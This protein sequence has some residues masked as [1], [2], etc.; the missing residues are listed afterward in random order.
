MVIGWR[1]CTS[2]MVIGDVEVTRRQL[3]CCQSFLFPAS[4][5]FISKV[6]GEWCCYHSFIITVNVSFISKVRVTGGCGVIELFSVNCFQHQSVIPFKTVGHRWFLWCLPVF[7]AWLRLFRLNFSLI[8]NL[9]NF[10]NSSMA[11][12]HVSIFECVGFEPGAL[13]V[14][15]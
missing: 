4:V 12:T 8:I 10:F 5:S 9:F 3:C 11:C 13:R 7:G 6:R 14:R 2:K 15:V 1:R